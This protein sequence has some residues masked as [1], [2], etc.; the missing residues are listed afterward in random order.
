M[1]VRERNWIVETV[2]I[3][4]NKRYISTL[5]G[6]GGSKKR[7]EGGSTVEITHLCVCVCERDDTAG[8]V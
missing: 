1:G 4:S 2:S 5:K 3:E 6:C 8:V 7:N